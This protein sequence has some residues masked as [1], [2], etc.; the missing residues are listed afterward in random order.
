MKAIILLLMLLCLPIGGRAKTHTVHNFVYSRNDTA[1]WDTIQWEDTVYSHGYISWLGGDTAFYLKMPG[2]DI[3][4]YPRRWCLPEERPELSRKE[5]FIN[6]GFI[7][8]H[9]ST[10]W[11]KIWS[12]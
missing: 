1:R 5:W 12:D 7:P 11:Y 10:T 3:P 9:D 2:A 8:N 4:F 6:N